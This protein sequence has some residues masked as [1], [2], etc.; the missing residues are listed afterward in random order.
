MKHRLI[1]IAAAGLLAAPLLVTGAT[2]QA[3]D[4]TCSGAVTTAPHYMGASYSAPVGATVTISCSTTVSSITVNATLTDT[5]TGRTWSAS[6]TC[7]G[8]STCPLQIVGYPNSAPY[9]PPSS[10]HAGGSGS[11]VTSSGTITVAPF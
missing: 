5:G 3:V 4:T 7:T 11:A 9:D 6:Q 1:S 8:T 10:Y 2:A